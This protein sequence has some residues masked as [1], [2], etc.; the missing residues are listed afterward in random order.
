MTESVTAVGRFASQSPDKLRGG[1]YTSQAIADWLAKWAVR[2]TTD[3]VLEP[4]CGDGNVLCS[5]ITR[6]K[7]LGAT[8]THIGRQIKGI[9]VLPTE[10]AKARSRAHSL[11]GKFGD[12]TVLAADFFEW[13]NATT[14]RFDAVVGNPPFIRYQSFPEPS[15]TLAMKLMSE[16]G[17]TPNK[18][19]N[20]WV[21]FVVASIGLLNPG[22]RLALVIPAELLQV[23]YAAQLRAF[24]T[25]SFQSVALISCNELFFEGAQQEVLLL[26]A[27]GRLEI[28]ARG[29]NCSVSVTQANTVAD[30]L[31]LDPT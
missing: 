28:S 10:A 9:E 17:L 20:I 14:T 25:D 12:S 30:L 19:T 1:Y 21:P 22:G 6:L 16:A 24:L 7:G 5:A 8:P 26:L 27:D 23:T 29:N 11:I 3:H 2:R 31:K 15:R 13:G 4:S 18:L